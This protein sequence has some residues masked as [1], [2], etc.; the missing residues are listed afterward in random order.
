MY[1][2]YLLGKPNT[3]SLP[4]IMIM[5]KNIG[6]RGENKGNALFLGESTACLVR[7]CTTERGIE[8]GGKG[9]IGDGRANS[10]GLKQRI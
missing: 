3:H 9:N 7:A 4:F 8:H 5:Y 6:A 1:N 10:W 2:Q